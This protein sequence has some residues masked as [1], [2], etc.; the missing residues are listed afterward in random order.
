MHLWGHIGAALFLYAPVGGFLF[1]VGD[2]LLALSGA[3]VAV[4]FATFPDID[5]FLPIDHRGLTHTVWFLIV[6]VFVSA[7]LGAGGGFA[8]DRP[9]AVA[10]TVGVAAALSLTSHL[11]ADSI[12]PMGVRP[13][14]PLSAWHHSFELTL[15]KNPRANATML[16]AGVVF[17]FVCLALALAVP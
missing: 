7:L 6:M 5:E 8:L 16:G 2:P 13:F 14:Y 15:A 10:T 9:I 4:S 17:T 3:F 1:R 12:T 11:L